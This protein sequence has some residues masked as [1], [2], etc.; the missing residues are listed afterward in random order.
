MT[1]HHFPP[2]LHGFSMVSGCFQ[3]VF[4]ARKPWAAPVG[5]LG[6]REA[7]AGVRAEALRGGEDAKREAAAACPG[8]I[9]I[10]F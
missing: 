5:A 3:M 1:F 8:L 6:V 2:V 4:E 10:Y 7:L 9:L